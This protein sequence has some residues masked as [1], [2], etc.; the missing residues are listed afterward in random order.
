MNFRNAIG[1]D[2]KY[3]QAYAG[4]ARA[5]LLSGTTGYA[6][7]PSYFMPKAQ[8]AASKALEFNSG[9]AEANAT[10]ATVAMSYDWKWKEA[11]RYF[12]RAL[13][14][15]S[16]NSV[17]HHW[18]AL[19]WA[20]QGN[21]NR[22]EQHMTQ[23]KDLDPGS[24]VITAGLGVIAY[25]KR[26]YE[27]AEKHYKE[28]LELEEDSTPA[29][30]G[31]LILYL[32]QE[33]WDAALEKIRKGSVMPGEG[34]GYLVGAFDRAFKG[35]F[36]EADELLRKV[37]EEAG[38]NFVPAIY[39]AAFWAVFDKPDKSIYWLSESIKDRSEY[40]IYINVDPLFDSI[41]QHQHYPEIL[42]QIGLT[43]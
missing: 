3:A 33:R 9:L 23:A 20:A 4:L 26:D 27:K 38:N 31:L 41:R 43:R 24:S 2:G 15:D 8:E 5:Y 19:Y 40:L 6:Q 37:R 25:Y 10:L 7:H 1:L 35:Q 22:A 42:R 16:S 21:L 14:L 18:Y 11:E 36:E 34:G 28:A 13:A 17:A 32:K 39:F 30:L 12:D 29:H